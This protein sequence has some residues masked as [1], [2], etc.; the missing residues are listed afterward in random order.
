MLNV[1]VEIDECLT[2]SVHIDFLCKKL[3]R[4]IGILCFLRIFILNA[5]LVKI[6]YTV[7]FSHFIYCCSL[8]F[9]QKQDFVNNMFKLQKGQLVPYII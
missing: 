2:W 7:I 4:K 9:S 5:V 6:N 3:S 1:G 8:V